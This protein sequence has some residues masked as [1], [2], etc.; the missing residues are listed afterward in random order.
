MPGDS[1]EEAFLVK[2]AREVGQEIS[3]AANAAY[4]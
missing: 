3:E 2:R 1:D 4:G